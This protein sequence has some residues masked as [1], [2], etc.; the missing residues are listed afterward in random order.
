[1]ASQKVEGEISYVT[2]EL[3]LHDSF[4]HGINTIGQVV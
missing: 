4:S 1:M 2:V 3:R